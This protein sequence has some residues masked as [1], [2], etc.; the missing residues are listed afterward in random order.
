VPVCQVIIQISSD[1]KNRRQ[2]AQRLGRILRPKPEGG[3]AS[4]A[5]VQ[6][7]SKKR[8]GGAAS[9]PHSH[10]AHCSPR[11]FPTLLPHSLNP[12]SPKPYH[13]SCSL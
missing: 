2:E 5:R 4:G 12:M 11:A 7:R 1:G 10:T 9:L 13:V 3:K 8:A 6:A